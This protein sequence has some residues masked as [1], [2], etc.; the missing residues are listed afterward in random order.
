MNI[1]RTHYKDIDA[2]EITD[3]SLAVTVSDFGAK[4]QSIRYFGKEY[5][6][7]NNKS[8]KYRLSKYGDCFT[9]GELSGFDDMFPCIS[10]GRY[11]GEN[12]SGILLPD[13]GEVWSRTWQHT[14]TDRGVVL[15]VNGVAL[16]YTLQKTVSI[17]CPDITLSYTLTNNS[18]SAFEY[19]WAAHPLFVLEKHTQL[20][21][22]DVKEII[23]VCGKQRY[24]GNDGE[25]HPW[26][27]S[28]AG[29]DMSLLDPAYKCQNKYYVENERDMNLSRIR[30]PDNTTVTF[31]AQSGVPY[32][33]I[34]TDE[35]IDMN[36]VAPEPCT[37]A[38]DA[39]ERA[40]TSGKISRIEEHTSC[41]FGLTISFEGGADK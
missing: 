35:G 11:K 16:P 20:E 10:A 28:N 38:Y 17:S 3:G 34:W 25:I 18:Q 41:S 39:Q 29:R 31:L 1:K 36:C 6:V 27:I 12:F 19:I 14:I 5:L 2:C 4:L 7:Q 9:E 22:P 37:G 21:L 40:H 23:N 33:G 24:L 15:S 30:Y 26:P 8:D 32:L 13:H